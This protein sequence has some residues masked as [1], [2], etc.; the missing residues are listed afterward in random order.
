MLKK[1][2]CISIL[3][4]SLPIFSMS[5]SM[6]E[7]NLNQYQNITGS[8]TQD[9]II[10]ILKKPLRSSG[11]FLISKKHGLIW[12]QTDPF[13]LRVILSENKMS[14]KYQNQPEESFT[15]DKNPSL[16]YFTSLF[17]QLFEGDF[18]QLKT[19]FTFELNQSADTWTLTLKPKTMPLN[20][21]FEKITIK[22]NKF[23]NLL[24]LQEIR[25]DKTIIR[26]N[27]Q[28]KINNLNQE[29]LNEY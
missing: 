8:F 9:R 12:K 21:I 11:T 3:C 16:F 7:K 4:F 28:K 19:N 20:K 15:K 13:N 14:Q 22:G 26:F 27:N 2:L 25:G 29:Q 5:L 24:V 6:L 17:T 18:E 23:I 1:I 10:A